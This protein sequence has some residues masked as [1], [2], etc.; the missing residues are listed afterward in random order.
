MRLVVENGYAAEKPA[1]VDEDALQD[2]VLLV[3]ALAE[4]RDPV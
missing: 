1:L 3:E 2:E 4:R